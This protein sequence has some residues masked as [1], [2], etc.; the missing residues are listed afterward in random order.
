M[1]IIKFKD[2]SDIYMFEQIN[3]LLFIISFEY[4]SLNLKVSPKIRCFPPFSENISKI[5][6]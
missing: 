4:L 3:S 5:S 6:G 1:I 2:I